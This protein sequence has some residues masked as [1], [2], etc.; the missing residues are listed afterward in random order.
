MPKPKQKGKRIKKQKG[1]S[2]ELD[3]ELRKCLCDNPEKAKRLLGEK[4]YIR[5]CKSL[6]VPPILQQ[7]IQEPQ[8]ASIEVIQPPQKGILMPNAQ[9]PEGVVSEFK[10][11]TMTTQLDI[12][13]PNVNAAIDDLSSYKLSLQKYIKQYDTL[14]NMLN[15]GN[16]D[17]K[18]FCNKFIVMY[19]GKNICPEISS[20]AQLESYCGC[21][22]S[23]LKKN[24]IDDLNILKSVLNGDRL[25][26]TQRQRICNQ[27]SYCVQDC[28]VDLQTESGV[29]MEGKFIVPSA[30]PLPPCGFNNGNMSACDSR[31][32]CSWNTGNK[33][34]PKSQSGGRK[35]KH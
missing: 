25:T 4:E 2:S 29:A 3:A 14:I 33:C 18:L 13:D 11:V 6:P 34:E 31:P 5:L 26:K 22:V 28:P 7:I 17:N 8:Q 32:D 9:G 35:K 19:S 21:S 30:P 27:I 15:S 24:I 10:Q 20:I 1:G 12:C 23:G 16:F